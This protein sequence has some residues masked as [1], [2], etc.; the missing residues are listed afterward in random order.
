MSSEAEAPPP[1]QPKASKKAAK[2]EESKLDKLRR[3]QEASSA[4]AAA[5]AAPP[6]EADPLADK[7]GEV[8]LPELQSKEEV[9]EPYTQVGALAAGRWKGGPWW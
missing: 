2:K 9:Q 5:A 6:E 4:V 7:Y 3:R 1:E 8:P